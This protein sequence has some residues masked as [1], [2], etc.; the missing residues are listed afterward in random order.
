MSKIR[1]GYF[2]ETISNWSHGIEQ[3]RGVEC[4]IL[5]E[6]DGLYVVI[7][8]MG[9]NENKS[10]VPVEYV[11]VVKDVNTDKVSVNTG[12]KREEKT[13]KKKIDEEKVDGKRSQPLRKNAV[14]GKA[15]S[16]RNNNTGRRN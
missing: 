14:Q 15:V 1:T 10:V 8:K 7:Y 16:R 6:N 2:K 12:K 4:Q 13:D 5:D 3:M 9:R 11:E